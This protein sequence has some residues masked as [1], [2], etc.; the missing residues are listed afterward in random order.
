MPPK[1]NTMSSCARV[2]RRVATISAWSSPMMIVPKWVMR[3]L[4]AGKQDGRRRGRVAFGVLAQADGAGAGERECF[5]MDEGFPAVLG[6]D[7]AAVG[8]LVDEDELA[9]TAFDLRMLS[10]CKGGV[11]DEVVVL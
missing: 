9:A 4:F 10:R 1:L 2:W 3:Y 5:P 11:D 7:I 6:E 8:A